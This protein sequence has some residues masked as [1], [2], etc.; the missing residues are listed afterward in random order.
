MNEPVWLEHARSYIGTAEI[1]GPKHNPRVVELWEKGKAGDFKDD[2]TPWCSAFVSAVL[3]EC[4]IVSA[5]TGWARAYLRWGRRL[6]DDSPRVGC[7]VIF[8]RGRIFGHVGFVV[9]QDRRGNLLVL[10]GNQSNEVN[11]RPFARGRV[12]G[13]RWPLAFPLPP[14]EGLPTYAATGH[15]STNEV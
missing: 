15:L 8:E 3:E 12:L 14:Y 10:G 2:E 1:V 6:K 13:Y 9:G 4:G 7:V 11:I 5:R